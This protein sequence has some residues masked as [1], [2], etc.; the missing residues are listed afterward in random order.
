MMLVISKAGSIVPST[1]SGGPMPSSRIVLLLGK[2][3]MA[4]PNS[5]FMDATFY[6]MCMHQEVQ[7]KLVH[8]KKRKVIEIIVQYYFYSPSS[9]E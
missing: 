6:I 8:F 9:K 2:R 1:L 4:T 3:T 7:I 5:L